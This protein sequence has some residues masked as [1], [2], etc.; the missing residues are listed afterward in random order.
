LRLERKNWCPMP[1][2][3]GRC[4]FCGGRGLTKEHVWPKWLRRHA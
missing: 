3:F 1:Q 2:Q 4:I